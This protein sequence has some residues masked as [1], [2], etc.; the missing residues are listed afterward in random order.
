MKTSERK[1]RE[2]EVFRRRREQ[3]SQ[4]KGRGTNKKERKGEE[5]MNK[6]ALKEVRGRFIYIKSLCLHLW[7]L[8]FAIESE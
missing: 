5:L 2:S 1:T 6:R 4:G 7:T 3:E 8:T